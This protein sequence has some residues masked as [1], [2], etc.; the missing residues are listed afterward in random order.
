M[1]EDDLNE[2]DS[3]QT[4]LLKDEVFLIE[5]GLYV[6]SCCLRPFHASVYRSFEDVNVTIFFRRGKNAKERSYDV[7]SGGTD[8]ILF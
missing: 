7:V 5:M 8:V 2:M 3:S 6:R 4:E 1:L